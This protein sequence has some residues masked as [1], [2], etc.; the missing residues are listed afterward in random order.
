M[1]TRIKKTFNF[2]YFQ[3][4]NIITHTPNHISTNRKINFALKIEND[5]YFVTKKIFYND[6]YS[7]TEGV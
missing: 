4:K 5:T 7:E 3:N 1:C 2:V 6:T